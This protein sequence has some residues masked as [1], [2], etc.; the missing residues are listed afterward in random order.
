VGVEK[1][2]PAKSTKIKSRQDALQAIR[3]VSLDIFYP[4]NFGCFRENGVF[5]QPQAFTLTIGLPVLWCYG[6]VSTLNDFG[7]N[8][9]MK[10]P[11]TGLERSRWA[12]DAAA[13]GAFRQYGGS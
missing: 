6:D 8:S 4:P 7:H 1:L 12:A 3:S 10:L 5:Q 2:H 11:T 9:H 13:C